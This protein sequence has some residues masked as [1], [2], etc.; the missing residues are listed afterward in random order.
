MA[1]DNGEIKNGSLTKKA[2]I[3]QSLLEALLRAALPLGVVQFDGLAGFFWGDVVGGG[4][5]TGFFHDGVDVAREHVFLVQVFVLDTQG[6]A[7]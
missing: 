4:A 6:P 3:L 2:A 7:H 5:G 1:K